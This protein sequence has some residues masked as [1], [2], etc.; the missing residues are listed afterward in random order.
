MVWSQTD[1]K[2]FL[3]TR[4]IVEKGGVFTNKVNCGKKF[5]ASLYYLN[6]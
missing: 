3:R 4:K 6:K 5:G 1:L 2:V